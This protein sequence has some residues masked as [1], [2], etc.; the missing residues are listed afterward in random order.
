MQRNNML[1]NNIT[2]TNVTRQLQRLSAAVMVALAL[3]N[4][5]AAAYAQAP[6]PDTGDAPDRSNSL[7]LPMETYPGSGIVAS[8]PTVFN[9]PIGI[10]GPIHWYATKD[11]WLGDKVSSEQDADLLPDADGLTNIDPASNKADRDGLDDGVDLDSMFFDQCKM[12]EFRYHVTVG[13]MNGMD[14]YVNLWF[15]F[16]RDGD[17]DDTLTCTDASGN[18]YKVP[19]WAVQDQ[20]LSSGL[21]PGAYTFVT[22]PLWV[23]NP[24]NA[25]DPMWM[26]ITLS[27]QKAP[28][29]PVTGMADGRGIPY[30]YR[31][32]ET[33][34]YL[35]TGK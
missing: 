35:L 28:L 18:T 14:R 2:R 34:D 26:R 11:A 10:P 24:P 1:I 9:D 27:E 17:W 20:V 19:E 25:K 31:T 15:D 29:S 32:G 22:P 21:T 30:G 33:E 6:D 12:I 5:S 8:Y 4:P 7:N 3:L 23:T 16:N 13:A